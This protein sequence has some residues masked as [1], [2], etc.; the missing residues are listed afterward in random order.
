MVRSNYLATISAVA[1]LA[2][3]P[4]LATE[5]PSA[6]GLPAVSELN[7]KAAIL[8]GS[9]DGDGAALTDLSIS[10]P[11]GHSFGLQ[12]DGLFGYIGGDQEGVAGG[13]GHLF[14]RDPAIGLIGGF[15]AAFSIGGE[16]FYRYA[17]EGQVYLGQLALEGY[18]GQDKADLDDGIFWSTIAAYYLTDDLRLTG[19]VKY[20]NW[21]DDAL[22]GPGHVG[23]AGLE[24][25]M[26]RDDQYGLSMFGEGRFD[27][28]DYHAV[29]GG[30]RFYFGEN[31]SLIR[32]HREDDPTGTVTDQEIV[33]QDMPDPPPTTT[34]PPPE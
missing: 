12:A 20:S 19:G 18:F 32:R 11:L 3:T 25:Q 9:I 21:R 1:F 29:W 13:G 27:G 33:D 14:W 17:G 22:Q 34:L 4:S 2:A 6:S 31:K 8:G 16:Q 10:L 26:I 24:Y 23:V 7:G 15:G 30:I 28:D 5:L